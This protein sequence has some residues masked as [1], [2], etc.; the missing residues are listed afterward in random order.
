ML[1]PVSAHPMSTPR[2]QRGL[3]LIELMIALVLG[4]FI[5]GSAST[6]LVSY[7]GEH[8]AAL[9]ESRLMQDLRASADLVTRDLRRAGY[10]GTSGAALWHPGMSTVL[11]NPYTAV[12]PAA[13]A[14]DAVSFRFSRASNETGTVASNE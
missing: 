6:L 12:A 13:A 10:W 2:R 11:A 8:R 9:I 3:S 1:G 5:V 14:S 4:L 7:L